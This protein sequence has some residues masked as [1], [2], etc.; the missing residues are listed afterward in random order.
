MRRHLQRHYNNT[1]E[2]RQLLNEW[3]SIII[4]IGKRFQTRYSHNKKIWELVERSVPLQ[5][6]GNTYFVRVLHHK[7]HKTLFLDVRQFKLLETDTSHNF[8]PTENGLSLP[9]PDWFKLL[10]VVFKLLT[11]H[12]R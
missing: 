10:N 3:E 11:K 1:I 4:A 9:I 7:V 8:E 12:K 6:F 5:L 2:I